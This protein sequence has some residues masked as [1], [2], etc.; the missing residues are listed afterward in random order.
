MERRGERRSIGVPCVLVCIAGCQR[1]TGSA[2]AHGIAAMNMAVQAKVVS[3]ALCALTSGTLR[4]A[5]PCRSYSSTRCPSFQRGLV[6]RARPDHGVVHSTGRP[7]GWTF[8]GTAFP[9]RGRRPPRC[10][11]PRKKRTQAFRGPGHEQD[12]AGSGQSGCR[13][14]KKCTNSGAACP[15]YKPALTVD[16]V[17]LLRVVFASPCMTYRH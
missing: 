5:G 13:D 11:S 9:A 10:H 3:L 17:S 12:C 14:C 1:S 2:S 4:G 6:V 15:G 16:G 7:S 8:T